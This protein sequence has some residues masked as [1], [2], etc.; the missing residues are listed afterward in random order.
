MSITTRTTECYK[1]P[2][3]SSALTFSNNNQHAKFLL[4][5]DNRALQIFV[6]LEILQKMLRFVLIIPLNQ[7]VFLPTLSI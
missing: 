6:V 3:V 4:S 7:S 2:V 5:T 1:Y